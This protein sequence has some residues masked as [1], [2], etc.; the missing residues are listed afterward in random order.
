MIYL[1]ILIRKSLVLE[2]LVMVEFKEVDEDIRR[3]GLKIEN[4]K[5]NSKEVFVLCDIGCIFILMIE[6]LIKEEDLIGGVWEVIFVNGCVMECLEVWIEVD[7]NYVKGKVLVIV[8]NILFVDLIV[9]NYIWLDVFIVIKK[10][11]EL[12]RL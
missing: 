9:G 7:I 11:G 2:V 12:V 4:G 5:V 10:D 6:K 1:L 8:M 3:I